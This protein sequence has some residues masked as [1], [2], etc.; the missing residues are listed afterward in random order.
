[1]NSLRSTCR[2]LGISSKR[3]NKFPFNMLVIFA[4]LLFIDR[5]FVLSSLVSR[6]RK[7]VWV[8]A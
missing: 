6:L 1:M 3:A 8:F 7:D 4:S 5:S 2:L